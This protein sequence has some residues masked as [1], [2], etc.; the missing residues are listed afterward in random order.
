VAARGAGGSGGDGIL[1]VGP[2]EREGRPQDLRRDRRHT[3]HLEERLGGGLR[4][5][6]PDRLL[7]EVVDRRHGVG[8]QQPLGPALLHERPRIG[9]RIGVGVPIQ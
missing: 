9:G 2:T 1:E 7:I 3:K 5:S 4:P 6:L 8:R